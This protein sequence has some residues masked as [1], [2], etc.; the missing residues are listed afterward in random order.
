[1]RSSLFWAAIL[2]V[3]T[4]VVS[5]TLDARAE[6]FPVYPGAVYDADI[7]KKSTEEAKRFGLGGNFARSAAYLTADSFEAVLAFYQSAAHEYT[8]PNR[9]ADHRLVLPAEILPG[10]KGVTERASDIVM[11]QAFFILDGAA[12]LT[13]SRRWLIIARPIIGH[14]AVQQGPQNAVRL[15]YSD[16][17]ETTAITYFE[18]RR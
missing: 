3:A 15:N 7:T 17:R 4:V 10:P 1:M 18:L 14:M 12:D 11:H 9:P 13:V 8:M 16:I 5:P 6:D 2:G